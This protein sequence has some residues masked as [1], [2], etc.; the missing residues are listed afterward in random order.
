M[1]YK[2]FKEADLEIRKPANQSD[3]ENRNLKFLCSFP[4]IVDRAFERLNKEIYPLIEISS[5]DKNMPANLISGFLKGEM[6]SNYP[7]YCRGTAKR[8]KMKIDGS[9][10]IYIKKLNA[11]KRPSNV[12][13]D[14][15]TMILRQHSTSKADTSA[16]I[17]LGYTA[18]ADMTSADNVFA[19]YIVENVVE[20]YCDLRVLAS[21]QTQNNVTQLATIK[22][23]VALKVGTVQL[24]NKKS[25]S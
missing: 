4:D 23:E 19:V 12:T 13:T 2:L 10:W 8:F 24:K 18:G 25:A 7:L 3:F 9:E 11:K 22:E 20:W 5:R 21:S 15:N 6:I 14:A 1:Q 16:N 17:F